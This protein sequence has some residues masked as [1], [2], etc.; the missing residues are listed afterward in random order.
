MKINRVK[1]ESGT[2]VDNSPYSQAGE[3]RYRSLF[4]YS[5]DGILIANSEGYY[6]D[7]NPSMCEMLGYAQEELI[8]L[9]ATSIVAVTEVQHIKPAL[10]SINSSA[11]Y[12]RQ[13]QFRRKDGTVFEAEVKATLMPDGN[14]LAI[15][16]DVTVIKTQERE[17]S[18]LSK[19]YAALSHVNQA[20][21]WASTREELFQKI[22]RVLVEHG[23][24]NMAWI[25]WHDP[26]THLLKPVADWGDADGY[27]RKI[28][29]Y[30]DDRAE[31]RGPSG[32]AFRSGKPCIC[33][34][35]QND[36]IALLWREEQIKRNYQSSAV[37]PI[38]EKG[39]VCG[40]LA[41]YADSQN[42]FNDKEI[43][44]LEEAASDVSFAIDN[45]L[46][47]EER[48]AAEALAKNEKLFSDTMIESM[49]GILYFYDNQG[50]F[51][52]WNKSF[53]AVSG[54]S[55]KEIATMHPLD[56]FLPEA[57]QSISKRITEVF[58]KGE[59]FVEAEFISK[60]GQA[61]PYFFTGRKVTF[62]GLDCLVGM[63]VDVTE[64]KL[65]EARLAE[66]EQKYRELVELANS[67]ILRW[68]AAGRITFLNEFGQR[69]FGY[70]AEEII[71]R[72]VI[73][74]IVPNASSD[75]RDLQKLMEEICSDPKKFEQNINENIKRNGELVWI[76]WTNK[77]V[78]DAQGNI[79]EIL[80]IGTDITERR[81]AEEAVRE[82]NATLEQRVSD[83]T[84]ELHLALIRAEAADK[85][86]SAFLATMSHELR[87]P[88]N[89]IIGFTGIILQ[90]LAGPLNPE[91]AKQ[92]GMVRSSARHLL[93]LI[94]DVLD[95]SKIE[96]GQLDVHVEPFD[97]LES[98]GRA[99][100]LVEPMLEKKELNFSK[101]IHADVS[102]MVSDRRR[103]EQI[104]INLLNNAIKFT[105]RGS[106]TLVVD[107]IDD[108]IPPNESTPCK[109][110]RFKVKDTGIG[111]KPDDLVALFQPFKQI[112]SGMTRQYD[113]T[114]LGL[115]ICRRL[116]SLMGG[117][118]SVNS[119]WSKGSEFIVTLPLNRSSEQS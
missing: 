47:E 24:F 110:V 111:M 16:R 103:L 117:E 85:I 50:K 91:Q 49:P 22:C 82:L 102:E 45:L 26:A 88:L 69:F 61:H 71:G 68:D 32:L 37:F 114:G 105:E 92:L 100:T 39:K 8:G 43:L 96:A 40:T 56:F 15:V 6:L 23:G 42:F 14:V 18:R 64:R 58:K 65:A 52:R 95:I 31:G 90:E 72:H 29:V 51:L 107:I 89:S 20:I 73:E 98:I 41:V 75:G 3:A 84:E 97:L 104:L 119:E 66:N 57:K 93:E 34:D 59:S 46:H 38:R 12:Q 30:A 112:D 108:F 21:V 11:D 48:I 67:I 10:N 94:N 1:N 118:I 106:V 63:G 109:A 77:F 115:V 28:K 83:R 2:D 5:P 74:T 101:V 25:G 62:N 60:D 99:I 79:I 35:L 81:K 55:G 80:S 76:A 113:G 70:S 13:W 53:E 78:C 19:L 86:K 36:P 17:I 44:L 54:Y 87:T 9:N 116:C 33:N 4:E 7:A 27:I